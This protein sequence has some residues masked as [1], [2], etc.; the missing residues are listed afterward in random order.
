MPRL[1]TLLAAAI[2]LLAFAQQTA[3]ADAAL[4]PGQAGFGDAGADPGAFM[5]PGG[6]SFTSSGELWVADTGNARLERFTRTGALARS[7]PA[8]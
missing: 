1:R 5:Q 6:V 3:D 8:S 7:S 2:V 4:I